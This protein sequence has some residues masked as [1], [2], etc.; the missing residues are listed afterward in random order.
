MMEKIIEILSCAKCKVIS[1]NPLESKCCSLIFCEK[2]LTKICPVCKKM[3]TFNASVALQKIIQQ[4]LIPCKFCNTEFSQSAMQDHYK[5]CSKFT[6]LCFLCNQE[7]IREETIEH[8]QEKH[9]EMIIDFCYKEH[10]DPIIGLKINS[11]GRNA[12]LG[13]TGKYYCKGPIGYPC[14]CCNGVCGP[15]NGCNCLPCLKLDKEARGLL[16][17][18]L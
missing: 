15:S 11:A 5:T 14:G 9:P 2:C 16:N 17:E 3:T 7:L 1:N 13:R 18:F 6:S 4:I 12:E 10:N 8:L